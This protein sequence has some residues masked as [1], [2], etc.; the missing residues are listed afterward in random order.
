MM[1]IGRIQ[2][3]SWLTIVPEGPYLWNVHLETLGNTLAIGS[4]RSWSLRK[5]LGSR[6][7]SEVV[8]F[9]RISTYTDDGYDIL[10]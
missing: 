9:L 2:S 4:M 1:L 5:I 6:I 3:P 10:G 7:E 8:G